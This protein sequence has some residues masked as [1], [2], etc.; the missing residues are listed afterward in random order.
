AQLFILSAMLLA[1][2]FVSL[3]AILVLLLVAIF[4]GIISTLIPLFMLVPP[5]ILL[6]LT[7]A[8]ALIQL[9][10]GYKAYVGKD[11]RLP[12]ISRL[13]EMISG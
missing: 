3:I 12:L 9:Y 1:I 10:V 11:I 8:V 2:W 4:G 5:L 7:P 6:I 13:A